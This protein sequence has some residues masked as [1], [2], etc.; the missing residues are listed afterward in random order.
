[1]PKRE[2]AAAAFAFRALPKARKGLPVDLPA[3][4]D[5]GRKDGAARGLCVP[6]NEVFIIRGV[7]EPAGD[8]DLTLML[9]STTGPGCDAGLMD[10]RSATPPPDNP[11]APA[12]RRAR[13]F[14]KLLDDADELLSLRA[15]GGNL[16]RPF[17][18]GPSA[19]AAPEVAVI[20]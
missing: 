13:A 10:R 19:P 17:L 20:F 12:E 14:R 18:D 8:S 4:A 16:A 3:S 5:I 9:L 6:R 15:R 7:A 1:M 2:G 11:P